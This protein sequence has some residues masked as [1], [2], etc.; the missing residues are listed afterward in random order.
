MRG[1]IK[2]LMV[3]QVYAIAHIAINFG[4]Y[5]FILLNSFFLTFSLHATCVSACVHV[6]D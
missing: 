6:L 5:I 1:L 4:F 3:V 2:W